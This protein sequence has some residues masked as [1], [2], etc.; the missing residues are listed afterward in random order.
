MLTKLTVVVILQYVI[1]VIILYTFN[2]YKT[3][4]Q[5]NLN[6]KK[7]KIRKRTKEVTL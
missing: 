7:Q 4:C 3:V 6:K 1:Q 5:L 2:L